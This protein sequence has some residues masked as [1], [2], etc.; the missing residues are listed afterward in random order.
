MQVGESPLILPVTEI[1][2]AKA[3]AMAGTR[4]PGMIR[5]H[6]AALFEGGKARRFTCSIQFCPMIYTTE[7]D[8]CRFRLP[9]RRGKVMARIF[10]DLEF[11]KLKKTLKRMPNEMQR[12]WMQLMDCNCFNRNY[13]AKNKAS[14]LPPE[15][16]Q[17]AIMKAWRLVCEIECRTVRRNLHLAPLPLRN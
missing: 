12:G 1:V 9:R 8:I 10:L 2:S 17:S 13:C 3:V 11:I 7:K 6:R 15:S 5:C 14:P 16:I 4:F